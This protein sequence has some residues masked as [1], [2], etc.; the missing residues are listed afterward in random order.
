MIFWS[1]LICN[2][3][4]LAVVLILVGV[5][6]T[7]TDDIYVRAYEERMD[8]LRACIV[9]APGTPYHDGLFFF[10]VFFAPDYP[11]EPPVSISLITYFYLSCFFSSSF[12]FIRFSSS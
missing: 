5:F 10:D 7:V 1:W 8:L 6:L 2:C 3:L 4:L 12:Q 11:Q 9:G